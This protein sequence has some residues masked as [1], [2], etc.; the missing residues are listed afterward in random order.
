MRL[1]LTALLAL[2]PLISAD[3]YLHYPRGGNNRVSRQQQHTQ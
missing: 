3:L 1:L 2:T